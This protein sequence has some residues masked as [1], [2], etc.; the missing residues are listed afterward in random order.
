M[1]LKE[2]KKKKKFKRQD[3]VKSNCYSSKRSDSRK[4]NM[5]LKFRET[6]LNRADYWKKKEMRLQRWKNNNKLNKLSK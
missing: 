1:N 6:N 5:K 2:W 4:K 3:G